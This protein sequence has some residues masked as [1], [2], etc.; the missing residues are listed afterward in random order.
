ML[1][2]ILEGFCWGGPQLRRYGLLY[3]LHAFKTGLLDDPLELGEKKRKKK[4]K[5]KNEEQDQV[6]RE[7][8]PV[9]R[10][11]SQGV[12]NRCIVVKQ[13]RIC[14]VTF[15]TPQIGSNLSA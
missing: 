2:C 11:F 4:D 15:Q 12:V 14:P 7:V 8:V 10:C 9:R 13:P 3:G 1:L 5:K 6:N